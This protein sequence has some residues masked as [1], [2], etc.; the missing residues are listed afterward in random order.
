[1]KNTCE[2]R[3]MFYKMVILSVILITGIAACNSS[4]VTP[5][6]N[7]H[8]VTTT[9][10]IVLDAIEDFYAIMREI[11]TSPSDAAQVRADELWQLLI[12]NQQV[13]LVLGEHIVFLYKG[14]A[15]SVAW[16]GVFNKWQ[17]PGLEG[18]RIGTTD[19]WYEILQVPPASRI[20]YKLVLN[21]QEWI[22]DPVNPN[23]VASGLTVDNSVLSM[24]GFVVT[25]DSQPR[26]DVLPGTLDGPFTIQSTDLG[27]PVNYDV[28]L[29]AGYEKLSALPVLYVLDGN[30]YIDERMGALPEILDNLIADKRINPV[31][32]VFIDA[33][34]PRNPQ[35][36]RREMEFIVHPV[37]HASFIVD[38]L[39]PVIDQAYRTDPRSQSRTIMGVSFGGL[40]AI[41]I[42]STHSDTFHN[43]AGF[44]PSMW[45]LF[46]P[47]YLPDR[48]QL[49]GSSVML[50]QFEA[51]TECGSDSGISCPALPLQVFLTSG[52]PDWD[53][54]DLTLL[55]DSLE[56][57]HYPYEYFQVNEGHAWSSWRGLIDEMLIYFFGSD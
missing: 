48:D 29:P 30:D 23:T 25:D 35:F 38:E 11:A 24:P 53:V 44:S 52:Y 51:A 54:G 20:E 10:P 2:Y 46:A 55:V 17:Q 37:E 49:D 15:D 5:T 28:Y 6:V 18:D 1:M 40:S 33:R 8:Q 14:E 4:D 34:D 16:L 45:V 31:L 42:A 9:P 47:E 19:L 39:I 36:N 22:L 41:Y 3:L 7:T 43:I 50:E 32:A 12:S 26:S 27:Y 21:G 13:P 57:E 56:S